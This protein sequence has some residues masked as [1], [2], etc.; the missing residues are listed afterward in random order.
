MSPKL[1]ENYLS[2]RECGTLVLE[3][4]QSDYPM[5]RVSP[6]ELKDVLEKDYD[7]QINKPG[8]EFFVNDYYSRIRINSGKEPHKAGCLQVLDILGKK[9][10]GYVAWEPRIVR[11]GASCYAPDIVYS[12]GFEKIIE[13]Q[14]TGRIY[15]KKS[16]VIR[17]MKKKKH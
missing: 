3:N 8:V 4:N 15:I 10:H 11:L 14:R 5:V 1:L 17:S 12:N 7:I 13:I 16:R 2:L 6:F 9:D